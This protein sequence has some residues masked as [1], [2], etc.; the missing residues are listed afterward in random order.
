MNIGQRAKRRSPLCPRN[1]RAAVNRA[2]RSGDSRELLHERAVVTSPKERAMKNRYSQKSRSLLIL[3]CL[4]AFS[5]AAFFTGDS[6]QTATTDPGSPF[7]SAKTFAD[8]VWRTAGGGAA[9]NQSPL[10]I[11]SKRRQPVQ[12]NPGAL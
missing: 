6:A 11:A 12:L 1:A 9:Q 8:G 10:A 5:A 3:S 4:L 7:P 2:R